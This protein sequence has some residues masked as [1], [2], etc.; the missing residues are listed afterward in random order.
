MTWIYNCYII[1]CHGFAIVIVEN[2]IFLM[3]SVINKSLQCH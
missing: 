1:K 2:D 3:K